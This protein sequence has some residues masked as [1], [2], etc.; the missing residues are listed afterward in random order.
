[1]SAFLS[2]SA[3]QSTFRRLAQQ[4]GFTL[5]C[6]LTLGLCIGANIA[7]FSV[8]DAI[9]L[10]PLPFPTEDRLI[11]VRNA[12]PGAGVDKS[13][14]SLPNYYERKDTIK[15]FESVSIIQGGSAIIGEAGSP[16]RIERGRI[17]FEFFDTLGVPLLMGRSFTEDEMMDGSGNVTILTHSFWKT[18]FDED[19]DI[20]SKT[21]Q[22]NGRSLQII[23][24]LSSDFRY[25]SSK[26][27]FFIPITSSIEDRKETNRH[28]NNYS[29][30]AR[31]AEGVSPSVA[32]AQIDAFNATLMETDPV[33]HLLKDVGF[34]SIV[35]SLREDHIAN[36]KPTLIILQ[37]GAL[38]LL[39]IGCVNLA[40]LFLVR[41]TNRSKEIAVRRA[42]GASRRHIALESLYESL[43]IALL[44][45]ILGIGVGIIG[46]QLLDT[47]GANELP[48]GST[49]ALDKRVIL[50]SFFGSVVIGLFLAV[51]IIWYYLHGSLIVSLQSESRGGTSSRGA[52]RVRHGFIT[53]QIALSFV[54]L[55]GAGMLSVSLKQAMEVSTGFNTEQLLTGK[56]SLPWTRYP[57]TEKRIAFL[58]Q[59]IPAIES[60]PGISEVGVNT[61]LPF[62]GNNSDNAITVEGI[63]NDSENVIRTHYNAGVQGTFFK[64]M[65]IPLKEGRLLDESDYQKDN[66]VCV[67]DEEFKAHYWSDDESPI[68]RRIAS[69]VKLN[70]ENA[71][72]IVGVVGSIKREEDDRQSNLGSVYFPFRH[73]AQSSFSLVARA[74]MDPKSLMTAV[75]KTV[76]NLD[77][78]LPIDDLSTMEER[79]NDSLVSK[80]SPAILST[81][82][83]GVALLLTAIGVYGA[84]AYAVAQRTREIGVRIALGARP[85][86]ITNLFMKQ[87]ILLLASGLSI[88]AIGVF[89]MG[90]AIQSILFETD[91]FHVGSILG[92]TLIITL[93]S[94][95]AFYLPSRRAAQVS[96]LEALS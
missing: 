74:G 71:Y 90:R 88:G 64:A 78:G 31:L 77:P 17:S 20:L 48:L 49:I 11:T 36:I 19:A 93:I 58:N 6:L 41:A 29:F 96:P 12:Y 89:A 32:Q 42:I 7:I 56:I 52:Q 3:I 51:P 35:D 54:L 65:G 92:A 14:A 66:R 21:F 15:A 83:A 57:D 1:M 23:G 62:S 80:R 76:L 25:L 43:T 94:Q 69:D 63:V 13:S 33:A 73:R 16:T 87:G 59:L 37:A 45:G 30:I 72:T 40:N 86:Q 84:L 82:F 70:D 95:F 68:G 27:K 44:G 60:L 26:A 4:R 67:I 38:C 46:I 81:I 24:V 47:I 53:I 39:L 8:V 61:S 22:S 9:V 2:I 34:H 75:R 5:T 28:S 55:S 18:Y 10:R 91:P 50:T 85:Q 79:I